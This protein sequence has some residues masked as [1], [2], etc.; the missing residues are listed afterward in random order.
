M[1][2]SVSPLPS[3]PAGTQL[4]ARRNPRWIA[5]GV[6]AMVLGALGAAALYAQVSTAEPV[7]VAARTIGRGEALD[8]AAFRV[9]DVSAGA[10]VRT[11]PQGRLAELAGRVALVDI[12][13]GT[14]LTPDSFGAPVVP[15][16]SVQLGLRLPQG[17]IPLTSMPAGTPVQLYSVASGRTGAVSAAEE[18]AS[19]A[20]V[21]F[22]ARIATAPRLTQDGGSYLVDVEVA[23]TDAGRL[24]Q[25][26]AAER[27]VLV[28][29]AER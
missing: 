19:P 5:V 9:V 25:L 24:A 20:G 17:R 26:A 18:A 3:R 6:L 12:A 22:K 16:G 27:L 23:A 29:E 14:L 7:L 11:V 8:S 4:R 2:P 21:A 15:V 13:E 28:R 1:D 10:G